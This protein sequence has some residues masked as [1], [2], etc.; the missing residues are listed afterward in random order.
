MGY[1][2]V[3][4]YTLLLQLAKRFGSQKTEHLGPKSLGILSNF[5]LSARVAVCHESDYI[6]MNCYRH[7]RRQCTV[8]YLI[9][10]DYGVNNV[11]MTITKYQQQINAQ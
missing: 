11:I 7:P 10:D 9:K 3:T 5:G 2:H 6:M 8:L 4:G 1:S